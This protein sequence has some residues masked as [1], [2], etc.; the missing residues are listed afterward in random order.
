MYQWT[1]RIEK[2]YGLSEDAYRKLYES[3]GGKCA[4]CNQEKPLVVDHCHKDNVVRGLLCRA[5][6]TGLGVWRDNQEILDSAKKYLDLPKLN[7]VPKPTPER[8]RRK[9]KRERKLLCL[10][11]AWRR[12]D[13]NGDWYVTVDGKQLF[14]AQ[15]SVSEDEVV[16]L[17]AEAISR[18]ESSDRPEFRPKFWLRKGRGWY[19]T[20]DQKQFRLGPDDMDYNSLDI[21]FT[22]LLQ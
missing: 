18:K 14:V 19:V 11:K 22:K 2:V 17:A 10:P 20:I 13:H 16:R 9:R 7:K 3:Q 1:P 15:A 6:N 12:T 21:A 5:C 8:R 4:I